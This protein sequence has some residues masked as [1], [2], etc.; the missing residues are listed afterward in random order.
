MFRKNNRIWFFF[1]I[2]VISWPM[3]VNNL[4]GVEQI[5]E[6]VFQRN[7]IIKILMNSNDTFFVWGISVMIPSVI[8][9]KMKYWDPSVNCLAMLATWLIVGAK[10]VGPYNWTRLIQPL[11][12]AKMPERKNK[13]FQYLILCTRLGGRRF[14]DD[15]L[16]QANYIHFLKADCM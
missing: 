3:C 7:T 8:I 1:R 5:T 15:E 11:Y 2:K 4:I 14:Y 16:C 10:L 9:S 12:D 13:T 6:Y